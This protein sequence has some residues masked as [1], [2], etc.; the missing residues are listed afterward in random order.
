MREEDWRRRD[1]RIHEQAIRLKIAALKAV[2]AKEQVQ[3]TLQD[4]VQVTL[5]AAK[6]EKLVW[7]P[8]CIKQ[9]RKTPIYALSTDP[10]VQAVETIERRVHF[11]N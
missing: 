7:R 8:L 1:G 2:Q 10:A 11:A 6:P 3:D 9:R 4:Q 5:A